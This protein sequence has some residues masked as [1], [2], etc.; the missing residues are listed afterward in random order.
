MRLLSFASGV[1]V[2][3]RR[4]GI[5]CSV[6]YLA[7]VIVAC[8]PYQTIAQSNEGN[9]SN[10]GNGQSVAASTDSQGWVVRD[11]TTGRLYYQQLVPVTMP[12]VRW[13]NKQV[14]TTVHRPQ[15]VSQVIQQQQT[16]MSPRTQVVMQPYWIGAWNPFRQP[17]LAYRY[18]P[19]TNWVPTQVSQPQV[20]LKQTMVPHQE[21][22]TIPQP[23]S[24][25]KTVQQLVQTEIPQSPGNAMASGSPRMAYTLAHQAPPVFRLPVPAGPGPWAAGPAFRQ[26]E[27]FRL[28]TLPTSPVPLASRTPL[29]SSYSAPLQASAG[30]ATSR[31]SSQAGL[32]PTVLR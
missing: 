4:R 9:G 6:W 32:R 10:S 12:Q 25:T 18:V 3:F 5:S 19:Q 21:T 17:T 29:Q 28:A 2:D 23:V 30:I 27:G 11:A 8:L 16:V 14:T 15:W 13:E 7:F 22:I 20:V 1:I 24:E 31:D 26:T